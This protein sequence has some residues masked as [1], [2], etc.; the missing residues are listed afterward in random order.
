M[1]A[2][3][4]IILDAEDR[5][6]AKLRAAAA[7]LEATG[8]KIK[9]TGEAT[10]KSTELF[11][12]LASLL[13]GSEIAGAAGQFAG[14]TEK[15]SGFSDVLKAGTGGALAFKAGLAGLV[16]VLA[17]QVGKAIGD[18][19]FQTKRWTDE[20]E[21]ANEKAVKL[22]ASLQNLVGVRF[23]DAK[24]EIELIS[25]VDEK[26][27]AY[28]AFLNQL[29]IDI[30][31]LENNIRS[32]EKQL[33]ATFNDPSS[34]QAW[35]TTAEGRKD[36]IER[37]VGPERERLELLTEQRNEILKLLNAETELDEKRAKNDAIKQQE[38]ANAQSAAYVENLRKEI[39]L[40]ETKGAALNELLSYQN[41][42]NAGDQFMAEEL[43]NQRDALKLAQEQEAAVIATTDA[44]SKELTILRMGREEYERIEQLAAARNDEERETIRVLQEQ[45]IAQQALDQQIKEAEEELNRQRNANLQTGITATQGRLITRG[46]AQDD[47]K[48]AIKAAEDSLKELKEIKTAIAEQSRRELTELVVIGGGA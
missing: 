9:D 12:Q 43:L 29:N 33:D 48:R 47:N 36:A 3:V 31:G 20:L 11:G 25:N 5:A 44:L 32:L 1:S 39:Q 6:T 8:K 22:N 14:L 13:G 7:Q 21:A 26:R 28:E 37:A 45:V 35:T 4:E 10:K 15:V 23:S 40:L 27:E 17:F 18:V 46:P 30:G 2:D 38:Q 42:N 34:L 24:L 16:G 19:I 41:T